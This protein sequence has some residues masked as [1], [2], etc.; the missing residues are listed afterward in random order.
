MSCRLWDGKLQESPL[1]TA[2]M[3]HPSLS[4]V[5]LPRSKQLDYKKQYEANKA[6]WKWTPDRPDFIQ[7]AKSSLQQSDVRG[8]TDLWRFPVLT[9]WA[10]AR[11][12]WAPN[13]KEV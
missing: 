7:A 10:L 11:L 13:E 6:Y 12:I 3:C 5:F 4:T 8:E 1:G 9:V 2:Y